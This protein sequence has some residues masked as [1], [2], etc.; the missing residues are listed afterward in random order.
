M[1]EAGAKAGR[2]ARKRSD[3][4][5]NERGSSRAEVAGGVL[6]EKLE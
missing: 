6:R 2:T 3:S 5:L 1:D 4:G